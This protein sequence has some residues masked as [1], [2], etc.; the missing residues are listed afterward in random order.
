MLAL[1]PIVYKIVR[2]TDPTGCEVDLSGM[3]DEERK[4]YVSQVTA[5]RQNSELFNTMYTSL[6]N[7]KDVYVVK[8][9]QTISEGSDPVKGQF[10]ANKEGG[11]TVTF[12]ASEE[13]IQGSVMSEEFFH[14]YQ[15]DNRGSY[16]N[17]EFNVEF[18]AKVFD[19]AVELEYGGFGEFPGMGDFQTKILMGDYGSEQQIISPQTVVSKSFVKDYTSSANSYAKHNR[20]NNHGN[21]HYKTNTTVAPYSL[22]KVVIDTY[23]KK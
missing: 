16:G 13:N 11:G 15:H 9:G 4:R 19:T 1:M 7:S 12:L 2:F 21:S 17:G 23:K 3:S 6:E 22:Q 18:E 10:A 8:F 5:Q 20:A 14:A